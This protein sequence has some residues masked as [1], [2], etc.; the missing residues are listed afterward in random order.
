M[1]VATFAC[2]GISWLGQCNYNPAAPN[3]LYFS[4]GEVVSALAFTLAVQQLLK[5]IVVLRLNT[6]YL[7]LTHIYVLVFAGALAAFAAAIV[8]NLPVLHETPIG[9]AL[10]WEVLA[11]MLFFIAYGA[12]VFALIVPVR[13]RPNR[14]E[15][16]ARGA[17]SL[18]ASA[19]ESDHIDFTQDLQRSLPT[20]IKIAA[21]DQYTDETSAFYDFTYRVQIR[22]AV[23]AVTLL[24]I[25][26]DPHY[27]RTLVSRQ[28]WRLANMLREISEKQL[29]CRAAEQFIREIG[30]QAIT[31]D[32]S[33]IT[34][35]IGYSGFG[36]A[37][38]LSEALFS[39]WFMLTQYNPL[40]S[41]FASSGE[42]ITPMLLRLPPQEDHPYSS[43]REP[44]KEWTMAL[45]G[46]PYS[47]PKEVH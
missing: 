13:V 8:P 19:Q 32:D 46:T 27:C 2:F 16:F 22:R 6:R 30:H 24:R 12:V 44:S 5:P 20:L 14:V 37:P 41:F 45:F 1:S 47:G 29:H 11:A 15:D 28:P 33:M 36:T 34:R 3:V 21:F 38:L 40:N 10:S 23:F 18:L 7:S 31:R 4:L 35:E 26:A 25:V 39:D 43:Q 9:F 17:A 42:P